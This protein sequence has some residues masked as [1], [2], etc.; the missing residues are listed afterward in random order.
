MAAT[1]SKKEQVQNEGG[2][3]V[4]RDVVFYNLDAIVAV[5]YRWALS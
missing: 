1:C 5:G 2:R 3:S 4:S